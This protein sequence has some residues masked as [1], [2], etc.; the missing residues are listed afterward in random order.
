MEIYTD[1]FMSKLSLHGFAKQIFQ[2][3]KKKEKKETI[4]EHRNEGKHSTSEIGPTVL[5]N[6]PGN[7]TTTTKPFLSSR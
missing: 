6:F 4:Q 7:V 3:F 5:N 2:I 1:L